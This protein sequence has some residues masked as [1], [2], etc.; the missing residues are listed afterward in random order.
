[1]VGLSLFLFVRIVGDDDG[2]KLF[3]PE[4]YEEY[5]KKVLPM[6]MKNRLFVSWT[7]PNGMDCKMVGLET[8]CF[9]NHR[10]VKKV[11]L[12]INSNIILSCGGMVR[13]AMSD[14]QSVSRKIEGWWFEARLVSLLLCC[15]LNQ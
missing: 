13:R 1:M 7:A 10:Y 4:E 12:L 6:R 3:T 14:S 8:M 5:K 15:F 9:C 2:G 11:F